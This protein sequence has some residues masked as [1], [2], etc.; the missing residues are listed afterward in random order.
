MAKPLPP[1]THLWLAW[2]ETVF[3]AGI[4]IALRS[5][6]LA[7]ELATRGS[8]PAAEYLRMVGEKQLAAAEAIAGAWLAL[9]KADGLGIAAAMLKPYRR[10]ARAN[11]RRLSRRSVYTR[12]QIR[13]R[14]RR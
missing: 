5:V 14:R 1:I 7:T 3:H 10:R 11:S 9:A 2:N 12:W 8:I 4:T 6:R 13:K